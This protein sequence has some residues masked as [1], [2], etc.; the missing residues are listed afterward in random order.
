M[1]T[2]VHPGD[3]VVRSNRSGFRLA[4]IGALI[5]LTAFAGCKKE[6]SANGEVSRNWMPPKQDEYMGV[7]AAEVQAAVTQRLAAQPPVPATADVWKHVRQLYTSFNQQLL[8][9]D[10]KGV[11]QP[12]VT[13]LLNAIADADSDAL[14]LTKYPL[15]ALGNALK[16]VD[17]KRATAQQLADA[18]VMLSTAFVT[19]G[20]NMMTGQM[21]PAGLGQAWHINPREPR[22]D[23]ALSLSIREDDFG[24]ALTRMRPQDPGYDSLRAELGTYRALVNTGGWP[25]IP[26]GK[27]LRRGDKA[28]PERITAL[29]QRLRAEGYLA[30]DTS[31]APVFDRNLAAAIADYQARHSIG[32]DSMLGTETLESLNEPADYR[33]A[34]IAANLERY[35]WLPRD[36][37]Q[38][39]I[40]VNVPQFYLRAY[41]S[42]Q[43]ALEMKVI[44]GKEY[45]DKATP[46]FS[47]SME[48]V[49]FRP[50][51][52][53][54]PDIAAKEIFPKGPDYIASQNMEVYSDHGRQA[55]RQRPG[56]KNALGLVKFLFP[57]DFNIYLHDTPNHE[58]FNKDVR[59][60]S[61]GCIRVEKPDEL[62][63][64]V[65]GWDA[66]KV[67][68]AMHG[69]DNRQITLPKKIP[70]YI[71]Y[72]TAFVQDGHINFGNDLYD[73]DN[74]LVQ[75]MKAATLTPE[76]Q[77]AQQALRALAKS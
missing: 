26:A 19:Y 52:N 75:Q 43:K 7:P 39:Y 5:G 27:Q 33:L 10:D 72:F 45:E 22:V 8:W 1:Q 50:Y 36:L 55:V 53:V 71:V 44:V 18:D 70:V 49:V 34:Q 64:W 23:S 4:T 14:D 30:G 37:G 29:R 31:N 15:T 40:L 65:L 24:A 62:A 21:D 6:R 57:N 48:Y 63:E 12:R 58:L 66:G 32:V 54:T 59:A 51:W 69:Q 61:H 2:G 77:Q 60:F 11:H 41:D 35:R 16:A 28:P 56:D 17:N 9:L 3:N 42:G 38:R 25:T 20:E 68:A 74:Q 73:R 67:E 46:V 76:T 47:D 13:A